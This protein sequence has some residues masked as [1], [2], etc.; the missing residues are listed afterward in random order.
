MVDAETLLTGVSLVIS[1]ST[2][3]VIVLGLLFGLIVG[4]IPGMTA[5]LALAVVL[6]IS[7]SL[8]ALDGLVLLTAVY[9]GSLTGGGI[10]AVLINTPGTPGAVA[11]TF[12]GYPMTRQGRQNE[13][14]G[15]Q[16]LSSVVGGVLSYIALILFIQPISR[17]ALQFGP[18]EMLGL[19]VMVLILVST[20]QSTSFFRTL[21]S[22]LAGI[23]LATIGMSPST[24]I[25]RGTFGITAL[26][27]GL[28][29]ILCIVGMFAIPELVSLAARHAIADQSDIA[30]RDRSLRKVVSGA[31]D[32]FRYPRT[33]GRSALTGLGVG[34]LP[35]AGATIAS[36]LSY[37]FAK[38]A[39]QRSDH[40]GQG[41]PEGVVAAETANNASEGGAMATLLALGIPGSA[42]TGVILGGFM[43]HG[44]VPGGRL[45]RDNGP[46]VYGLLVSNVF[47][48]L[49]LGAIALIV[50][51]YLARLVI[52]P[53]RWVVPLITVLMAVGGFSFRNSLVDVAVMFG[54]GVLGLAMQR[55]QFSL[56]AMM[57]GLFLGRVLDAEMLRFSILFGRRPENLLDRPI[58]LGLVAIAAV[59]IAVNVWRWWQRYQAAKTGPEADVPR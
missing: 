46:L 26:E 13:A 18:A 12:D 52:V 15:L 54:F 23:L 30:G 53:S 8:G 3:A 7:F 28:P 59:L 43:A 32:I 24:G 29:I 56:V 55:A 40:F 10:L 22:G 42:S 4:V 37:R 36:L 21:I 27:D 1:W 39:S 5:A 34:L 35:A 57:L 33:L 19:T 58:A 38:G 47:Q 6:P 25:P 20:L 17:F 44:L 31:R 49:L 51:F 41:E 11:T 14:L 45:F 2:L 16:I 50:A 48:F 9:T